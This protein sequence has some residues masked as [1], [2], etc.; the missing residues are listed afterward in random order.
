[1]CKVCVREIPLGNGLYALVSNEDYDMVQRFGRW[2]AVHHNHTIYAKSGPESTAMHRL[3]MKPPDTM[4]VH[5][6]NHNGLHNY[7]NNLWVCTRSQNLLHQKH[8]NIDRGIQRNGSGYMVRIR[9]GGYLGT[10][11]TIEAARNARDVVLARLQR[12]QTE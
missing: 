1:M 3:I 6:K 4:D 9:R 11:G 12:E 2:R 10:Y 5:H 8:S 7:R